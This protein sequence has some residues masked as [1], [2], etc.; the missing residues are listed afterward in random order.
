MATTRPPGSSLPVSTSFHAF[1]YVSELQ[2][3]TRVIWG[4]NFGQNNIT[5]AFLEATSIAKAF[6]SPEIKRAGIVLDAIEIGNEADFY[7][8]GRRPSPWTSTEYIKG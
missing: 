8:D 4:L 5:A 7:G 2:T 1:T 3:D 6:S